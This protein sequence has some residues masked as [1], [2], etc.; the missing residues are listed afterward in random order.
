MPHDRVVVNKQHERAEVVTHRALLL[1]HR[2]ALLASPSLH[3][4]PHLLFQHGRTC[5]LYLMTQMLRRMKKMKTM[6][7]HALYNG[8]FMCKN[9]QADD[10][11]SNDS[12]P[13]SF[14]LCQ[15]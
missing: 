8:F 4:A 1:R 9:G 2:S 14:L 13:L 7:V 11:Q 10:F 3:R 5:R 6:A 12:D 15:K